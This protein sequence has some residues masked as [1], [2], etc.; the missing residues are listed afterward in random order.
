MT[1]GARFI[2]AVVDGHG[3]QDQKENDAP[4]G[5]SDMLVISSIRSVDSMPVLVNSN[6]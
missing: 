2:H 5:L 6:S 4:G 1:K 3:V